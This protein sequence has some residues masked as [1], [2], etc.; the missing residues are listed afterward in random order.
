LPSEAKDSPFANVRYLTPFHDNTL[1]QLTKYSHKASIAYDIIACH[2]RASGEF[3]VSFSEAGRM[4]KLTKS[5][6]DAAVPRAKQFT[7]WCSELKGFG[8][9]V[10]PSGCCTYFVDYRNSSG[11]RRRM[12]IGRHG[13]ITAEQARKLAIATLGETLK[14]DDPA[15]ERVTRRNALTVKELSERYLAAAN[16]GLILGKGNR[17]KKASSLYVDRGRINRHILPL[18]GSKRVPDL[19][20]A[21]I[22]RFMAD[23]ASGKTSTVQKTRNKRGKSIV[24]GG[25]GT[26]ARTVGLLGGMLTYALEQGIIEKNP[27][28]GIRKPADRIKDRRLT[29]D[30]YRLLG[31]LLEENG[32]DEQ[33]QMAVR[34]IRFIALTGC[35]RS[36][37]IYLKWREVD[38]HNSCIRLIDSKEGKSVRAIGLPYAACGCRPAAGRQGDPY[39]RPGVRSQPASEE[40]RYDRDRRPA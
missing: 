28:H 13:T 31:K 8:V 10:L 22:N 9:F 25:L 20:A 21:D 1:F 38:Q 30:E 4:P 35:R 12:K 34:I 26:A 32:A 24:K 16:R 18:L 3:L 23:V 27:V 7:I 19:K 2:I 39:P 29:E 37:A 15:E 33:L 5:V 36:E 17:P 14:G 11:V 6:V 40:A